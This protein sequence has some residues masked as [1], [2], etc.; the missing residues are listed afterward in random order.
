MGCFLNR[1]I[2]RLFTSGIVLT[3]IFHGTIHAQQ[4]LNGD[5]VSGIVLMKSGAPLAGI[6]AQ[7]RSAKNLELKT[8]PTDAQGRFSVVFSG[9]SSAYDVVLKWMS[10][11][12]L[13]LR[14]VRNDTGPAFFQT[15]VLNA[16]PG[17]EPVVVYAKKKTRPPVPEPSKLDQSAPGTYLEDATTFFPLD[18]RLGF[19]NAVPGM[20]LLGTAS[21]RVGGLGADQTNATLFGSRFDGALLP[22]LGV[23]SNLA[24][25]NPD[26]SRGGFSGGQLNIGAFTSDV[27]VLS[28]GVNFSDPRAPWSNR[29]FVRTGLGARDRSE[30]R[31]VGK[32]CRSR[33]SPYH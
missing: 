23:T 18:S 31:R 13:R 3:L 4:P 7:I 16:I 19:G 20:T 11:P 27:P 26:A 28:F 15:I 32:E 9:S 25:A 2:L 1:S 21:L 30:E 6:V 14:M 5:T 33:W 8:V 12:A 17:M 24:I 22:S 10:I 29:D